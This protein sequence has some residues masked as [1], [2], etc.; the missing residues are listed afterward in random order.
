MVKDRIHHLAIYHSYSP[1]LRPMCPLDSH[2]Q[3]LLEVLRQNLFPIIDFK[4]I[5]QLPIRIYEKAGS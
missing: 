2:T 5:H 3:H 4:F 1:P